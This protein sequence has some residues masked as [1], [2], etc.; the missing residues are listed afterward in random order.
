MDSDINKTLQ[1]E[2]PVE[3]QRNIEEVPHLWRVV[4]ILFRSI[5]Y[6]LLFFILF[7]ILDSLFHFPKMTFDIFFY[8]CSLYILY[9]VFKRVYGLG[10]NVERTFGL[11]GISKRVA[12]PILFIAI[13]LSLFASTAGG[14]IEY[15][16]EKIGINSSLPDLAL[17]HEWWNLI[18]RI[19]SII[20]LAPIIEE[21]VFRGILLNSI[22][23]SLNTKWAIM[24]SSLLFGIIHIHPVPIII[25]GLT[26]ILTAWIVIKSNS[27]LSGFIIH[28][29]NNFIAVSYYMLKNSGGLVF[30]QN[31]SL[32]AKWDISIFILFSSIIMIIFGIKWLLRNLDLNSQR[33]IAFISDYFRKKAE[34]YQPLPNTNNL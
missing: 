19:I 4:G 16:F 7:F 31:L 22:S 15:I 33:P 29:I 18:I 34:A 12:I 11:F 13:N 1:E 17:P 8:V 26:T 14:L 28:F 9:L 24:I 20:V 5:L 6:F 2:A 27:I 10:F 25:I 3:A 23:K 21:L 30:F 32:T